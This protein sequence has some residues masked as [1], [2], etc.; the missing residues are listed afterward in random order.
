M[1]AEKILSGVKMPAGKYWVGDP[2]YAVP[3]DRWMEWLEAGDYMSSPRFQLADLDGRPV[4]GIGT[5]YGDGAYYGS[6]GNIYPVDAGLIGVTP[7]ELVEGNPDGMQLV[8]FP[9]DFICSYHDGTIT[10]GHISIDTD[11]DDEDDYEYV[12]EDWYELDND[13][14]EDD[15]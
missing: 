1:K 7:A 15:E 10:L 2:C 6:D 14:D 3:N 11:D 8:N 4:L 5:A 12:T 9:Q 13:Y